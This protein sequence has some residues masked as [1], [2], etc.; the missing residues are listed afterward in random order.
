MH[1]GK[2]LY[3]NHVSLMKYIIY[4]TILNILYV[5]V[6]PGPRDP[7]CGH[8]LFSNILARSIKLD[9]SKVSAAGAYVFIVTMYVVKGESVSPIVKQA[10]INNTLL[11]ENLEPGSFYQFK[12]L[13]KNAYHMESLG[14]CNFKIS[15]S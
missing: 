13:A 3:L 4:S 11:F 5:R 15:T 1:E 10:S 9:L 7:I 2:Y 14:G 6:F 12:I 8:T